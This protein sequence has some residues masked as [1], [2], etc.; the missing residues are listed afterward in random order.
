MFKPKSSIP[1]DAKVEI[2]PHRL[3]S[4][5]QGR[6]KK[7]SNL[8]LGGQFATLGGQC[9]GIYSYPDDQCSSIYQ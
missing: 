6:T 1:I 3:Y 7:K 5:S 4:R 9:F 2:S 8:Q